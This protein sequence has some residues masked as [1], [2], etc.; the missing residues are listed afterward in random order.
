MTPAQLRLIRWINEHL[1]AR[2][3]RQAAKIQPLAPSRPAPV[4]RKSRAA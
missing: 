3:Q 4:A 2:R 1:E